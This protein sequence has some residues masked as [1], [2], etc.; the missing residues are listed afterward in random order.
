[1]LRRDQIAVG[2]A[3][4]LAGCVLFFALG[5]ALGDESPLALPVGLAAYAACGAA[6]G[7]LRPDGGWRWGVC[8]F[9][10]WLPMTLLAVFLGGELLLGGGV[11]WRGNLRDL[12]GYAL[13]LVAACL[14]AEAG[15]FARLRHARRHAADG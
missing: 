12:A 4:F 2:V 14:G 8:L 5:L 9:A 3:A 6:F 7:Y 15:A 13:L 11:D 10:V 1:M